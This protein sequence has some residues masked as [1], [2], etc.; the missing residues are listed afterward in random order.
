VEI[1]KF[2]TYCNTYVVLTDTSAVVIDP[3]EFLPEIS[4]LLNGS[5]IEKKAVIL[6][7]GHFDHVKDAEKLR[8]LSG[9]EI[10]IH[11][12]DAEC[13]L[14]PQF[15]LC[16]LFGQEMEPFSPDKTFGD[17][18]VLEIGDISLEVIHTPGH[19]KGSSCFK[20]K[21][22]LFTGDTLFEGS[23]GRTDFPRSDTAQMINSLK[24]LKSLKGDYTV[25]AGH[26]ERTTLSHEKEQNVYLMGV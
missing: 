5:G 18:D 21:D 13:L 26:G 9:A 23:I 19:T 17:G 4:A 20:M 12:C 11:E 6:T 2:S 7:H 10:Y 25:L 1:R 3:F 16:S 24:K 8:R 15:T 14:N 22:V